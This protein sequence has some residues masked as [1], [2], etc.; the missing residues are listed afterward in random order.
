M[1]IQKKPHRRHTP[2]LPQA[3]PRRSLRRADSANY[4]AAPIARVRRIDR[5]RT[6]RHLIWMDGGRRTTRPSTPSRTRRPRSAASFNRSRRAPSACSIR[7]HMQKTRGHFRQTASFAPSARAG[8]SRRRQ[9]LHD[10]RR[11]AAHPGRLR[12]LRQLSSEPGS[13]TAHERALPMAC[14]VLFDAEHVAFRRAELPRGSLRSFVV[15]DIR[16]A[17]IPRAR[18]RCREGYRKGVSIRA[19]PFAA[20]SIASSAFSI[21]GGRSGQRPR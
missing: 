5:R 12:R 11:P 2:R 15:D 17:R 6:Q 9:S 14:G 7:Q 19:A 3:G 20:R 21:R 13:V 4:A 1:T 18:V 10:D 16:T 8:Q